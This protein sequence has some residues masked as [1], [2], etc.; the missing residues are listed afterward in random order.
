MASDL[1]PYRP[2]A[3]AREERQTA[4][5]LRRE[6]LPAKRAAARIQAATLVAHVGI[7][8]VETLTALEVEALRRQGAVIDNRVR[9]IVDGFAALVGT[10]LGRLSLG[11]E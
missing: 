1:T 7:V 2:R 8:N 11:G 6:Q 5:M 3:L 9:S 4:A 10:E